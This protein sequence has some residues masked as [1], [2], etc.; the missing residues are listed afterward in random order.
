MRIIP[1]GLRA[2]LVEVPEPA[3]AHALVAELDRRRER[4]ELPG[5][6]DVVPGERT[7]LVDGLDDPA[8]LA[9]Q[10]ATWRPTSARLP[11]GPLVEVP[12]RYD[13]A[14]LAEV[15]RR[16]QVREEDVGRIHSAP[17]YR[18]AFCGFAPG[19]GYLTGLPE[20]YHLP[21]RAV[22]RTR[23]PAG[24]VA[25][26]GGYAGIYPRDSPGGW[27]LLGRTDLVL[28]DPGRNPV[29]L[30]TP[31]TRVRFRDVDAPEDAD[32]DVSG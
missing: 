2:L 26:A 19:F 32:R 13:G 5:V 11:D 12:V 30:L 16:W 21:R 15:A 27:Q 22:P 9:A 23:V 6:E 3:Y 14:D 8:G 17:E 10:L 20:R 1:V 7:V 31:G 29:A 25:L 28:F 4:G 18:V 24:S